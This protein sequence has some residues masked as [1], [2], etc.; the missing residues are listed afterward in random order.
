MSNKSKRPQTLGEEIGNAVTHGF[1]GLLGIAGL[2]LM[3]VK[4]NTGFELAGSIVFGVAM[5]FVYTFSCLYHCFKNGS[6]VKKVFKIFD[7]SAIYIQI[8]GTYTPILLCVIGGIVGWVYFGIQWAVVIIGILLDIFIP[9]KSKIARIILCLIL[10]WSGIMILPQ[11]Y[12]F[13][14]ML[15]WLVLAGGVMY[16]GGISFYI[17][18]FKYSHFVWHFFVIF[19]TVLH[20][21]GV[22]MYI[23]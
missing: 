22:Y 13:N 4:S 10:G 3:I 5:I 7:H 18:G 14:P 23:L 8:A 21:I 1:G 16:S 12:N 11:M 19:G 9:G 20:F 17:A 15:L 2:V 6:T